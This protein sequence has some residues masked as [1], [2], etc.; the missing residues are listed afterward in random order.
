MR[1][2]ER[3]QPLVIGQDVRDKRGQGLD[4]GFVLITAHFCQRSINSILSQ[5]VRICR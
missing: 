1:P 2:I 4:E 3:L 5:L